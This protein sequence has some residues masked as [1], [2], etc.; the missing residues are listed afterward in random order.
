[1]IYR[2]TNPKTGKQSE[3]SEAQVRAEIIDT[4]QHDMSTC[5]EHSDEEIAAG[6]NASELADYFDGDTFEGFNFDITRTV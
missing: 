3:L 4:L 5:M 2:A 6:V 1:M